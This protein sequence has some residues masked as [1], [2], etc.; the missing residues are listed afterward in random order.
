M[1]SHFSA[2]KRVKTN[3]LISGLPKEDSEDEQKP[4]RI[5]ESEEEPKKEKPPKK[6][7]KPRGDSALPE[8]VE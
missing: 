7:E 4:D 5:E 6:K 8:K 1:A 2:C 3:I